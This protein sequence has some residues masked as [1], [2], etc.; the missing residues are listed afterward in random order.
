MKQ[1]ILSLFGFVFL[2]ACG[3]SKSSG[4]KIS[5][6]KAITALK[7]T[8]QNLENETK[9]MIPNLAPPMLYH[10]REYMWRSIEVVE[11]AI[12]TLKGAIAKKGVSEK[13][14]AAAHQVIEEA[15]QAITEAESGYNRSGTILREAHSES[16]SYIRT[17]KDLLAL[18][19]AASGE[20]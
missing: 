11:S 20:D 10:L 6:D 15:N 13:T 16:A 3:G 7:T 5:T 4:T 2:T 8:T 12:A 17:F 9:K 18:S 19:T 14:R 1:I